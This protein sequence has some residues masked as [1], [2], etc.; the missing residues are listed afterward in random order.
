M[1]RFLQILWIEPL[2]SWRCLNCAIVDPSPP[3]SLPGGSC[4]TICSLNISRR[5]TCWKSSPVGGCRNNII[6][7]KFRSY[8][9][10]KVWGGSFDIHIDE[11]PKSFHL[12]HLSQTFWVS[13]CEESDPNFSYFQDRGHPC[14]FKSEKCSQFIKK[15]RRHWYQDH[16]RFRCG[17][18]HHFLTNDRTHL[19][20]CE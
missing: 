13:N 11:L 7:N 9:H 20:S 15:H 12:Y 8:H 14:C 6:I 19:W 4:S 18:N 2:W 16:R 10:T 3:G 17:P 1:E 5:W